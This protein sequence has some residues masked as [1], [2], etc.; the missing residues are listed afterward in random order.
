MPKHAS[1]KDEYICPDCKRDLILCQGEV[2]THHFRHKTDGA[3]ACHY[4]DHPSET[5]I[6][7]DAKM[8]LKS[9]LDA[10]MPIDIS[11]K[12]VSCRRTNTWTIPLLDEDSLIKLEHR[13]YYNGPKCADVAYLFGDEIVCLF[14]I[15]HTHCTSAEKRPEPWF[16]L[17]A[18]SLIQTIT[19]SELDS[20]T[21]S[22]IRPEKCEE[23]IEHER[24][25][26]E[27]RLL[28]MKQMKI[29]ALQAQITRLNS[30]YGTK[31]K[32]LDSE[33]DADTFRS[34]RYGGQHANHK[35]AILQQ[36]KLVENDIPYILGN[37]TVTITHP[38][39]K[40]TLKR[41]LVTDKTFIG[42]KWKTYPFQYIITWYKTNPRIIETVL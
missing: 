29:E 26:E 32:S 4:Y 3:V 22:C 18:V 25:A 33:D 28:R 38:L 30:D 1:K 2:R 5:Q 35:K 15:C 40:T 24:L 23:C 9:I 14:E 27:R 7:K 8:L 41:S 42:G 17:A 6:H 39:T 34:M 11:R 31:M 37:N 13:F 21:L 16:E 19:E 36:I 12:C 20:I 10:K